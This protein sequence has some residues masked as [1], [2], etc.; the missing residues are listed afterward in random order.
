MCPATLGRAKG[1]EDHAKAIE[2]A[3]MASADST[4]APLTSKEAKRLLLKY[5][6]SS[7]LIG[8]ER[9]LR[10]APLGKYNLVW[11]T[12]DSTNPNANPFDRLPS[13]H[14]GI[15]TALGLGGPDSLVILVWNHAD[16]GS[17]ALHRPTIADAEDYPHYRPNP[18]ASALWGLTAPLSPNPDDLQPQPE[19]VMP[20]PT[21]RGLRLPFRVV[22]A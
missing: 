4:A 7:R 6:G 1:L 20:E 12:F 14:I 15:C 13:T 5:S 17:P 16:S 9:Y 10:E 2:R 21:S 19:V 8:F 18:D 11:A 22:S 3:S